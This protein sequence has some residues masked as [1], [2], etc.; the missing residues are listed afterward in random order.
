LALVRVVEETEV[1]EA[2]S[3]G[4]DFKPPLMDDF[5]EKLGKVLLLFAENHSVEPTAARG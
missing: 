2:L 1:T 5:D 4:A 3:L